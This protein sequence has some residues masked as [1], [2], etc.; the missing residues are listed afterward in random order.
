[1]YLELKI[2][3]TA[4]PNRMPSTVSHVYCL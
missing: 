2:L 3:I 1:L 4:I